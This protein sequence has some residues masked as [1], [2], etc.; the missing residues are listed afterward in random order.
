M[1]GQA[2]G[3]KQIH[4]ALLDA[5]GSLY[6]PPVTKSISVNYQ[7]SGGG[8]QTPVGDYIAVGFPSSGSLILPSND[9]LQVYTNY[10][11]PSGGYQTPTWAYRIDSGFPG[12][13]SPHGGTQI[14]GNYAQNFLDGQTSGGR[15]IHV[16]LLDSNGS[17][18]NP[19]VTSTISVNYQTGSQSGS[20]EPTEIFTFTN[21]GATGRFGP[22]QQQINAAYAATNLANKV[23]ITP[24]ESK[25]GLYPKLVSTKLKHLVPGEVDG[26][27]MRR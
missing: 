25:S 20:S 22:T 23:S 18:H 5:N 26:E 6:N 13:G 16:A 14:T 21:A 11:S 24:R 9:T 8:Y 7:S 15:Q 17:L 1:N 27:K 4:V 3:T 10:A 19:P 12:Y 2:Y